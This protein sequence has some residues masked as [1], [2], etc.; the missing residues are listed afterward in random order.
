MKVFVFLFFLLGI[1]TCSQQNEKSSNFLEIDFS[2][3]PKTFYLNKLMKGFMQ[4]VSPN[5]KLSYFCSNVS[6]DNMFEGFVINACNHLIQSRNESE[7]NRTLHIISQSLDSIIKMA[8][9]GCGLLENYKENN[10]IQKNALEK[11]MKIVDDVIEIT[12]SNQNIEEKIL[13][14]GSFLADIWLFIERDDKILLRRIG[15]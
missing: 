1:F 10:N 3:L 13:K 4:A 6:I 11:L 2:N 12:K 15:V 9:K 14:L 7:L 8:L 5:Y